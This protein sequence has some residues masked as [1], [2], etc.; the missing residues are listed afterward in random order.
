MTLSINLCQ[1][2][3]ISQLQRRAT[4]QVGTCSLAGDA[5]RESTLELLVA[6]LSLIGLRVFWTAFPLHL[7]QV[8]DV[9][10]P[11]LFVD[12]VHEPGTS[13]LRSGIYRIFIQNMTLGS[14]N[15]GIL[16]LRNSDER[17]RVRMSLLLLQRLDWVLI[18][19][20]GWRYYA[21]TCCIAAWVDPNE[22]LR[23]LRDSLYS[24]GKA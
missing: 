16:M 5:K 12:I 24:I 3:S 21:S 19:A 20:Y 4:S 15:E 6:W 7:F 23:L 17:R 22:F 1:F 14:S 11:N 9:G 13:W 2:W 8:W 10:S 18:N